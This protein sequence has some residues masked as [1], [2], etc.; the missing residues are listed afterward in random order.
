MPHP[1]T[2]AAD[3]GSIL[4]LVALSASRA[5][6]TRV[7]RINLFYADTYTCCFVGDEHGELI[8][9]PRILH[10]VVF[11]G[12]CPTTFACRAL[13]YSGEGFYFD[14]AAASSLGMIDDSPGKLVIYVFHPAAF[15][16]LA[17]ANGSDLFGFLERLSTGVEAPA[18][19]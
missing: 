1:S 18:H 7:R 19:I 8:E 10:T 5:F 17:L 13:A 4:C 15:L 9:G 11:A 2:V 14:H 16:S 6:L 12:R 3:I